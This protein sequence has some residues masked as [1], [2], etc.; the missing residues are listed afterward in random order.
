M[1]KLSEI[2]EAW[3]AAYGEDIITEYPGFLQRLIEQESE[4]ES[5]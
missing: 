1:Y 2:I 3:K 5:E 4:K